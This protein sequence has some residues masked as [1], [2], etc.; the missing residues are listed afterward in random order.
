M[1]RIKKIMAVLAILAV[2]AGSLGMTASA[3]VDSGKCEHP[4]NHIYDKYEDPYTVTSTHPV[5]VANKPNGEPILASCT[6]TYT[7]QKWKRACA[8][9]GQVIFERTITISETHSMHH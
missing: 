2:L 4:D 6:V 9:C 7:L 8:F 1:K 3:A 5:W